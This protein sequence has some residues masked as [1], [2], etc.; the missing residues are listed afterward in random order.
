M[1]VHRFVLSIVLVAL[2]APCAL[3]ADAPHSKLVYPG[4]DGKLVYKPLANGDTILDF[5]NC[6][7][8]GGGVAIPEAPVRETLEPVAEGDDTA[9]IQAAIDRVSALPLGADGLRGAVLLEKGTYRVADTMHIGTSGVVLRGEGNDKDGT[10]ILATGTKKRTVIEVAG[11]GGPEGVGDRI[12][13]TD[14]R[15]P[16]GARSF[17][18]ADASTFHPGDTVVVARRSNKEWIHEINMD[19][20]LPRWETK[21]DGTKRDRT[22]QWKP[23]DLLADRTIVAVDGNRITIDAPVACAIE[24][25]WGGGYVQ[26]VEAPGRI[27]NVGVERLRSVSDYNPSVRKDRRGVKY[28]ADEKHAWQFVSMRY[29]VNGWMRDLTAKHYGLGCASA[30]KGSKWITVQDCICIEQ[31]AIL[32]GSRRYPFQCAGEQVLFTRCATDATPRHPYALSSR[33]S[34]PNAFVDCYAEG[35]HNQT[36]PHHRW[37]VG[38]LFDNVNGDIALQDRQNYGTGHGWSGANYVAW[39]TEGRLS[40]QQPPTAENFAIGHVGEKDPG[41]FKRRGISWAE[42]NPGKPIPVQMNQKD[43]W[44]E[45]LGTHVAP[46]SL[47]LQQLEDRLGK[48]AVETIT[49]PEQR[50][51]PI[52]DILAAR[53]KAALE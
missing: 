4:P 12:E 19:V 9:R 52:L 7:Y 44:W 35:S 13:V 16:V 50:K 38:G 6:G 20:I 15:V 26:K 17:T 33:L 41:A 21:P 22:H 2:A 18:V 25:Q 39:N 23:F 37:S 14:E 34:G 43:G 3:G 42:K 10:T 49:I 40:C 45:S 51:G 47:Y 46:R 24:K 11:T 28:P 27:E 32:K 1:H 31:V 36:E 30:S 8:R 29:V 48:Q 5:S 53:V